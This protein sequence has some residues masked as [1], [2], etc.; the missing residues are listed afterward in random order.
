[1]EILAHPYRYLGRDIIDSSVD[2]VMLLVDGIEYKVPRERIISLKT[3]NDTASIKTDQNK[4]FLY[5]KN[6][7]L[8]KVRG[9]P[10]TVSGVVDVLVSNDEYIYL[11][12]RWDRKFPDSTQAV[13]VIVQNMML[14]CDITKFFVVGKNS[15]GSLD[16]RFRVQYCPRDEKIFIINDNIVKGY[17]SLIYVE[18]EQKHSRF[19]MADDGYVHMSSLSVPGTVGTRVLAEYHFQDPVFIRYPTFVMANIWFP[20]AVKVVVRLKRMCLSPFMAVIAGFGPGLVFYFAQSRDYVLQSVEIGKIFLSVPPIISM[21]TMTRPLENQPQEGY[22]GD[23]EVSRISPVIV[24]RP[25]VDD[26][27]EAMYT[28]ITTK[29]KK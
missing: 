1:L 3:D 6:N 12:R 17:K 27:R 16:D 15:A 13:Q 25:I 21:C 28:W 2:G 9:V 5:D 26:E 20:G 10:K 29:G 19:W 22:F 11:R 4:T 18:K 7:K 24:P 8:Y 23:D 14:A